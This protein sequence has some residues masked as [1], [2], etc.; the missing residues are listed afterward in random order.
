MIPVPS[1]TGDPEID[2]LPLEKRYRVCC[3]IGMA[4]HYDDQWLDANPLR[5]TQ[6]LPIA[7]PGAKM[8]AGSTV[9]AKDVGKI[10]CVKNA[11]G[12]WSGFG[13]WTE[14][15]S[16]EDDLKNGSETALA[17]AAKAA[18]SSGSISTLRI[19]SLLRRSKNLRAC[20][21]V[22]PRCGTGG[23]LMAACRRVGS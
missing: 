22:R 17:S 5:N 13:K 11:D 23:C 4:A 12:T 21:S 6:L 16:T 18:I 19:R 1:V 8:R 2:E 10:P 9:Q 7:P 20:I 14:H 15:F 3:A